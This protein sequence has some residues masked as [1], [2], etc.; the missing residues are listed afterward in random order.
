[1]GRHLAR[2]LVHKRAGNLGITTR[3]FES[4][5]RHTWAAPGGAKVHTPVQ[6]RAG[7]IEGVEG[8]ENAL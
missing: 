6:L 7:V 5:F 2:F 4:V 3:P 8:N 1:M